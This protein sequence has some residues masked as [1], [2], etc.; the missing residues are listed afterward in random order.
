MEAEDLDS[1][2]SIDDVIEFVKDR[3][4]ENSPYFKKP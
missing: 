1:I 4:I 3:D 2:D